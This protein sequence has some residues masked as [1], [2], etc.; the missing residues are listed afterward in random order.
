M[1]TTPMSHQ[2]KNVNANENLV[3][4]SKN[5]SIRRK[6]VKADT[7]YN[8]I[9]NYLLNY[10]NC[11]AEDLEY[12][13]LYKATVKGASDG[14]KIE[15]MHQKFY[16]TGFANDMKSNAMPKTPKQIGYYKV[17]FRLR[18]HRLPVVDN[19]FW[20]HNLWVGYPYSENNHYPI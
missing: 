4:P 19:L 12:T 1:M 17:N 7:E 18:I 15:G 16:E 5:I 11:E 20:G 8:R 14:V 13:N 9:F 6:I 10:K 3:K 2:L